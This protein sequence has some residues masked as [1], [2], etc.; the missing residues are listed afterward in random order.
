MELMEPHQKPK[1]GKRCTLVLVTN[2][3]KVLHFEHF[4]RGPG[5]FQLRNKN[6]S[7][8]ILVSGE[9]G[10]WENFGFFPHIPIF[11]LGVC[12]RN[13]EHVLTNGAK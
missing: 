13:V 9:Y 12:E 2:D 11:R 7:E 1:K 6:K 10:K 8:Y 5:N 3:F 4:P